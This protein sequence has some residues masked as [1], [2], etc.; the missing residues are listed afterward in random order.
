MA[1]ASPVS[2][3]RTP[4]GWP[5]LSPTPT[6]TAWPA[7]STA[8]HSIGR[9]ITAKHVSLQSARRQPSCNA[10]LSVD[11]YAARATACKLELNQV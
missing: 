8:Q 11:N 5:R 4:S 3:P 2:V 1:Q 9:K 10:L 6:H 7:G